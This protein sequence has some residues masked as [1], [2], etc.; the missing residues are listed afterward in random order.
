MVFCVMNDIPFENDGTIQ[1]CT[2]VY[3][4]IT[5]CTFNHLLL[6]T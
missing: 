4:W 6:T 1:A 2:F 3:I 5:N